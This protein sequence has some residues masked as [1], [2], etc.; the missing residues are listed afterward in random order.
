MFTCAVCHAEENRE[1]LAGENFRIDGRYVLV[2]RIP[3][4]VSGCCG[5]QRFS[6]ETTER[7]H[8]MVHGQ[9]EST[10]SVAMQVLE[11]D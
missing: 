8:L 3:A 5:G 11:C 7:I 10:T 2:D 6:C 1:E 4:V 9:A